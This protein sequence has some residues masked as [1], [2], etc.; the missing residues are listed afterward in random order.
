[1]ILI[2]LYILGASL[3]IPLLG[4]WVQFRYSQPTLRYLLL[5]LSLVFP[6]YFVLGYLTLS[7]PGIAPSPERIFPIYQGLLGLHLLA[8][9]GLL[10]VARHF[11]RTWK[12]PGLPRRGELRFWKGWDWVAAL[13]GLT[14]CVFPLGARLAATSEGP[15]LRME[16]ASLG[17]AVIALFLGIRLLMV[18]EETYRFTRDY[19]RRIGRLAMLSLGLLGVFQTVLFAAVVLYR[20][21]GPLHLQ[22]A[23]VVYGLVYPTALLGFLRYRLGD[24]KISIPR[25][26][27]YASVTLFLVGAALLGAAGA[28]YASRYFELQASYFTLFLLLFSAGFLALLLLG[29]GTMRRRISRFVDRQFFSRKYDYQDQFFRLH[30]SFLSGLDL[31]KAVTDLVENMKYAVTVDDAFVFLQYSRDG[32]F[33]MHRNPESKAPETADLALESP[34]LNRL[35]GLER[36]IDKFDS[37]DADNFRELMREPLL[38]R[39]SV[40]AVFPIRDGD[41]LLGLLALQGGRRAALDEEDRALVGVFAGWLARATAQHR[42]LVENVERK[43]FESFHHIASFLIH[44]IKNQVATLNMALKN[45]ERNLD[46][47]EFQKSLLFSIKEC[48]ENLDGLTGKLATGSHEWTLAAEFRPIGPVVEKAVRHLAS[49]TI[50]GVELRCTGGDC[51]AKVDAD[52]LFFVLRNLINNALEAMEGKGTIHVHYGP[53]VSREDFLLQESES[54]EEAVAGWERAASFIRVEDRGPGMDPA[55]LRDKLFRPFSTTKEKGIGIGLYQCR[56]LLEQMGG[57]IVCRSQLGVGTCFWI[58]LGTKAK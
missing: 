32:R 55:F 24:E 47:P 54:G 17:I 30:Q 49:G 10:E 6:L 42:L 48:A 25:D 11:M 46:D 3:L 9:L 18:M 5:S 21:F 15:A 26:S 40:D 37:E 7:H 1:M 35:A 23:L 28:Y 16:G 43:Q 52:A 41:A 31:P 45:A 39:L 27:V 22:S 29:S 20:E 34:A 51:E 58:L 56:R 2:P 53:V 14:L 38:A 50:S 44:D 12:F 4:F 36:A 8:A 33:H 57:A 19:Q 13:V